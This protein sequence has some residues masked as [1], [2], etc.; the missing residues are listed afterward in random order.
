MNDPTLQDARYA[1]LALLVRRVRELG[2]YHSPRTDRRNQGVVR[3]R[4]RALEHG[5]AAGRRHVASGAVPGRPDVHQVVV[6]RSARDGSIKVTI[7]HYLPGHWDD[8]DYEEERSF[9]TLVDALAWVENT[10][11][12]EWPE[13]VRPR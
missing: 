7:E 10:C 9:L 13:F 6:L 1:L 2:R 4:R 11:G 5:I 3:A 12:L 8:N